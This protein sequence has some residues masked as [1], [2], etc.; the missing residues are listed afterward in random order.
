[1]PGAGRFG[2]GFGGECL[3]AL[4]AGGLGGSEDA[5]G[6]D[7]GARGGGAEGGLSSDAAFAI[8][9]ARASRSASDAASAARRSHFNVSL[10]SPRAN[11]VAAV[12]SAHETSSGSSSRTFGIGLVL[13]ET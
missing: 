8:S 10:R 1:M 13:I 3:G 9:S 11:D 4:F 6:D 5:A 7:E 12:D 2:A